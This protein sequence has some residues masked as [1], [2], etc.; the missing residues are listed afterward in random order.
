MNDKIKITNPNDFAVFI[1]SD[2]NQT[3]DITETSKQLGY[4]CIPKMREQSP[5]FDKKLWN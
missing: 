2:G 4:C 5:E 1:D 3:N